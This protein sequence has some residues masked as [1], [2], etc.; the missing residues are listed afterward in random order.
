MS[1]PQAQ[2]ASASTAIKIKLF[3]SHPPFFFNEMS[4]R[5]DSSIIEAQVYNKLRYLSIKK[6][7]PKIRAEMRQLRR[8]ESQKHF[9]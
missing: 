5:G 9:L 3:T 6:F 8:D 7:A 1:R 2:R 4:S